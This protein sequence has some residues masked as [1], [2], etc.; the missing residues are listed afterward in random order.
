M[1]PISSAVGYLRS[2]ISGARR[3]WDEVQ[4]RVLASRLG[5]DLRRIA[6]FGPETDRPM[7]RLRVLASRLSA[8]AI[9]TPSLEHLGGSVPAPVVEVADVITV[10]PEETYARWI[11]PP[12]APADMGSR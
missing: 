6:V 1:G 9:L 12:D 5:Y 8:E 10:S 7:H 2:D 11:I 4:I 3:Q